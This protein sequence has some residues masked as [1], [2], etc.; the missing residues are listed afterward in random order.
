MAEDVEA[1]AYQQQNHKHGS[2]QSGF[3]AEQT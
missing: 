3:S 2:E 1:V